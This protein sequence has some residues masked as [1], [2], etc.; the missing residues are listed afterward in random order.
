MKSLIII[1]MTLIATLAT[2]ASAKTYV[3][4]VKPDGANTWD[5][6]VFAFHHDEKTGEVLVSSG[7]ILGI[8]GHPVPAKVTYEND[9]R[10]T[11]KWEM[12]YINRDEGLSLPRILYRATLYKRTLKIIISSTAAGYDVD[13]GGRGKCVVRKPS[14]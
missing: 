6:G 7:I 3:C 2:S 13:F 9:K 12:R 10:I 1:A 8:E 14:R 5:E 4:Q 11:A